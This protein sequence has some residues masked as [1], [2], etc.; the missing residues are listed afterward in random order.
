MQDGNGG[1]WQIDLT[2]D[3]NISPSVQLY[4]CHSGA[5][6]DIASCPY[7]PYLASLGID[8]KLQLRNYERRKLLF[9]HQFPAKGTC[10]IWMPL[11]VN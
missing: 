11:E 5:V 4:R 6:T 8:G 1:L 3:I 10:M 2:T 7:G 9:V